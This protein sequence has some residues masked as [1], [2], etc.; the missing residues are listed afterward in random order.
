[1]RLEYATVTWNVMEVFVTIA[2]G[3]SAGS[4]AL[5][6]FGLDSLVEVFASLV[7]LWHLGG[8]QADGRTRRAMRLV[9]FAFFG[10]AACLFAG[11]IDT[12][13]TANHPEHSPFGIAY[14]GLTA[15][16]MFTLAWRKRGLGSDLADHP[17]ATEARLTFLDG[18]LASG[19]VAALVANVAFSAWWADPLAAIGVAVVAVPEGIDAW[20]DS[21]EVRLAS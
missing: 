20:H 11:A 2:A 3:I 13:V 9:S 21:R 14:L 12:L 15:V 7:V 1:M 6:A 4:I 17:L 19:V 18:V 8:G 16:V 10:L 5:V